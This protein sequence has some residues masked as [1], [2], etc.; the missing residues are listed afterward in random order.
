MFELHPFQGDIIREL[1]Q[2]Y[3]AGHR[4]QMCA[5]ATGGGKTVVASHL[6]RSASAKGNRSIFIVDRIELVNQAADTLQAVGLRVGVMQ[7]GNTWLHCDD[8]VIVGTRQTFAARG[9]PPA[10]FA[11]ID[12]A[13]VLAKDHIKLMEAWNRVPF[14][15]LS[16]TPLRPD[17]GGH[18]TN[19]VRGPT[20]AWLTEQGFLTPARAFCPG[21]ESIER[22]ISGVKLKRGDFVSS[23]LAD[24]MNTKALIGDIIATWT[25][26]AIDRPTLVFAVDIAHSKS[27]IADFVDAGVSA[28][29]IDAY[30]RPD[31]RKDIIASFKAGEIRVLS[32]VNVLGIGFDYPG[33]SCAILAR[34]TLSEALHMQQLGRVIRRADG[35]AD[36]LIL[37]HAGNTLRF[38]LPIHFEVPDLGKGEHQAASKKKAEKRMVACS[39]CGAVMESDQFTCSSCGIDRPGRKSKVVYRDGR[40]VEYGSGD[41]GTAVFSVEDRRGWYQAFRWYAERRGWKDGWAFH[42]FLAKFGGMKPPFAWKLFPGIQPSDEQARWIRHYQI[43]SAKRRAA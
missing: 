10:G 7:A 42:A 20:V 34:P 12:E 31:E 16:A 24:A 14:I 17:L 3:A 37:D 2:G 5:L 23:E 41:D 15:G 27:V 1:R 6:I 40:L 36:A 39:H 18:F 22:A 9:V 11:I 30:T 32:S 26:K 43:R 35:K 21:S 25:E 33:A 38:G 28:A 29:H 19:L 4:R 8:E 13:H